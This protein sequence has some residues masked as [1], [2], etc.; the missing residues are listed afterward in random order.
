[1]E[2][3]N[4]SVKIVAEPHIERRF[5]F[6]HHQTILSPKVIKLSIAG[7][8]LLLG[9]VLV[10]R[11]PE[12]SDVDDSSGVRPPESSEVSVAS[13]GIK[14]DPYSAAAESEKLKEQSKTKVKKI[15]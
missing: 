5:G 10:W 2:S 15:V 12:K 7:T 3:D 8:V 4:E 9:V 1:M 13:Q 14:V 6:P 11:S